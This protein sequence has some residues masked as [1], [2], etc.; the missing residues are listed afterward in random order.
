[1]TRLLMI[2]D[3]VTG[4]L[5]TGVQLAKAGLATRVLPGA[6]RLEAEDAQVLVLVAE[7]RHL[8]PE[9]AYQLVAK[10]AGKARQA[11]FPI[12]YKKTDSALRGNIGAE[13][14]ALAD[15]C[16]AS[17]V[18]FAPA[19]PAAGRTTQGGVHYVQ[20][21]PVAESDFG[22][23]P[24]TPVACSDIPQ[25]LATRGLRCPVRQV[26][27]GQAR[28]VFADAADVKLPQLAAEPGRPVTGPGLYLFD[29]ACDDDLAEI[30]A[31]VQ[32]LPQP[33]AETP[34]L[35]AGCAGLASMLPQL[36]L[37]ESGGVWND[38]EQARK[39]TVISGG[40]PLHGIPPSTGKDNPEA[41]PAPCIILSGSLHPVTAAQI[42]HAVAVGFAY[43]TIPDA[44]RQAETPEACKRAIDDF[45]PQV[46]QAMASQWPPQN[47]AHAD[48]KDVQHSPVLVLS[49]PSAGEIGDFLRPEA[50][51]RTAE[52]LG[53]LAAALWAAPFRPR[54]GI[55]GG[56]TLMAALRHGGM[57]ALCPVDELATGVVLVLGQPGGLLFA[58]KSGGLGPVDALPVI[59]EAFS[60]R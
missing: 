56:D 46:E 9:G 32:A 59:C 55:V 15:A 8:S 41:L 40:A 44:V 45:L 1:M 57:H 21:V 26:P 50:R 19:Y 12:I 18:L 35:L 25:W 36:L 58:T 23:D 3:D 51:S 39:H 30:F 4:A 11:G 47:M 14:Q 13:L 60:S 17:P 37:T 27:C 7:T 42:K 6:D 38:A 20:G 2:A 54:L 22:R 52:N 24:F 49:P 29:A 5:D 33:T 43:R 10:L 34:L 16:P 28:A 48:E 31:A 53:R